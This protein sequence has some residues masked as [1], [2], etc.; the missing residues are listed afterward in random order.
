MLVI[1]DVDDDEHVY[2][3]GLIQDA[4]GVVFFGK[5]DGILL[6]TTPGDYGW[7]TTTPSTTTEVP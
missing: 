4:A 6:L 1:V 3:A 2:Y 5:E 7:P